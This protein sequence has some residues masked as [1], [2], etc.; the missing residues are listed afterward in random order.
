VLDLE[1]AEV[2]GRERFG[3]FFECGDAGLE[4]APDHAGQQQ[5][6]VSADEVEAVVVGESPGHARRTVFT[7]DVEPGM[8][9]TR[10]AR[11]DGGG[12]VLVRAAFHDRLGAAAG[13]D[14]IPRDRRADAP[15]RAGKDHP[16]IRV[17]R[18]SRRPQLHA[19]K[20]VDEGEHGRRRRIDERADLDTAV[21]G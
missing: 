13:D 15:R 21:T 18:R 3:E 20:V 11:V 2:G 17:G 5:C 16:R 9:F 1:V 4:F 8:R 10:L 19:A 12:K 14:A 6:E 7:P